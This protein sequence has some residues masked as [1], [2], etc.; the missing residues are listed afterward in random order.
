MCEGLKGLAFNIIKLV[1]YGGSYLEIG[2]SCHRAMWYTM[3][4][5]NT[6]NEELSSDVR[7]ANL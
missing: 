7:T 5:E 3:F 1:F 2:S 6:R 4:W